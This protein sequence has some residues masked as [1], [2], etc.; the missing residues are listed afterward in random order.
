MS[1]TAADHQDTYFHCPKFKI[2]MPTAECHKRRRAEASRKRKN[3]DEDNE[4]AIANRYMTKICSRC[5]I[6][7]EAL[8]K[9]ISKEEMLRSLKATPSQAPSSTHGMKSTLSVIKALNTPHTNSGFRR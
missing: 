6:F 3:R 8:S 5:S 7:E 1:N 2:T 9:S 4:N